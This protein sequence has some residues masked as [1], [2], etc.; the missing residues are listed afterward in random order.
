M[1]VLALHV[2]QPASADNIIIASNIGHIGKKADADDLS[3]LNSGEPRME[4]TR[5]GDISVE[6]VMRDANGLSIGVV[7]STWRLPAGDSKALVLHN[8][9]LVRDEMASKTPSLAALFEPAR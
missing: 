4:V 9:E 1:T 2:N 3:V 8:A 5:T 7:G 6:L